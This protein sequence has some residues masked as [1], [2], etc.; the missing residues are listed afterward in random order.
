MRTPIL[1]ALRGH[2]LSFCDRFLVVASCFF[3]KTGQNGPQKFAA[4]HSIKGYVS[5]LLWVAFC[6]FGFDEAKGQF[7]VP[8]SGGIPYNAQTGI[9]YDPG[10]V[11]DYGNNVDGYAY[12]E[13][14]PGPCQRIVL[15]GNTSGENCCD[16]IRIYE[17][18]GTGGT[19]LATYGV[20]AGNVSFTGPPGANISV[21]FSS[22]V[23]VTGQGFALAWSLETLS[24]SASMT[25]SNTDICAGSIITLTSGYSISTGLATPTYLWSTGETTADIQP[26]PTNTTTYTVTVSSGACAANA[27]TNINV[28]ANPVASVSGIAT[29]CVGESTT[30]N[31]SGGGTYAWSTGATTNSINVSPVSTTTYTV[32]VTNNG[33]TA[34]ASQV[35]SVNNL[36]GSLAFQYQ[37]TSGTAPND[38]T[39]CPNVPVTISASG[40]AGYSWGNGETG[41]SISATLLQTGTFSLTVSSQSGCTGSGVATVT[42]NALASPTLAV[43][44]SDGVPNDGVICPGS[45]AQ[46]TATGGNTFSWSTGETT[47]S[48]SASLPS[49]YSVS[50]TDANGCSGSTSTTLL[51]NAAATAAIAVSDNS[52]VPNDGVVCPGGSAQF[53]ASGG[54]AYLWST[55]ETTATISTN[56]PGS[57]N[58]SVTNG[59]GCAATA[60]STLSTGTEPSLAVSS[61]G[62]YC[63]GQTILF[64]ATGGATYAWTGPGA[65]T[66]NLAAPIR[67]NATV[68]MTGTYFVTATSAE[69][70]T[71]SSNTSVVV[72]A[73]IATATNT[74]PYCPTESIELEAQ[75]G[76]AFQW[77]GPSGF[78]SIL[79]APVLPNANQG[80]AGTYSVTVS[81]ASGCS[82]TAQTTVVLLLAPQI[83]VGVSENSAQAPN[84]GIICAGSSAVLTGNDP[85]NTYA[86]STGES[87][88][89]VTITPA[90]TA[91]YLVTATNA[92]GCTATASQAIVVNPLPAPPVLTGDSIC[93]GSQA[94][95][96]GT[97]TGN[98]HW[99]ADA[100]GLNLLSIGSLLGTPPLQN[101]TTYW[102][103]VVSNG[104]T[105]P[106]DS[107]D[108][109]VPVLAPAPVGVP[110]A[111]CAGEIPTLEAVGTGGTLEWFVDPSATQAVASGPTFSPGALFVS[112]T[113]WVGERVDGCLGGRT[114][115]TATIFATPLPPLPTGGSACTDEVATLGATATDGLVHWFDAANAPTEIAT[116]STFVTTPLTDTTV[117]WAGVISPEGCAGPRV[118]VTAIW[119]PPPPPATISGNLVYC[120][121]DTLQLNGPDL[122]GTFYVWEG[123]NGLGGTAPS[124]FYGNLGDAQSG[125]Y[126]LTLY[127]A[128]G[129]P[130]T[131]DTVTV[132]INPLPEINGIIEQG[133]ASH[134][135]NDTLRL[136]VDAPEGVAYAWTLADGTTF[137]GPSVFID[138]LVEADHQGFYTLV[139]TD[140]A[141]GCVSSVYSALVNIN[142]VPHTADASNNGPL[143]PGETAILQATTYVGATYVWTRP[144]GGPL[145]GRQ[146]SI[147]DVSGNNAGTYTVQVTTADGC[148]LDV[149]GQTILTVHPSPAL[150]VSAPDST[151]EGLDVTLSAEGV[152]GFAWSPVTALDNTSVANPVAS[153][154]VPGDY[155][156]TVTL[157]DANNCTA[158]ASVSFSV[159]EDTEIVVETAFTPNGDGKNDLFVIRNVEHAQPNTLVVFSRGGA[160]VFETQNYQHDW[161]GLS[162]E[163][164]LPPGTYWYVFTVGGRVFKGAVTILHEN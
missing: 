149:Q 58:V 153:G 16:F 136:S 109:T 141:T 31:A 131:P 43:T 78:A 148:L 124:I 128:A 45:S 33:C 53:T 123:P 145:S 99:Y 94:S 119:L 159:F 129:C 75:G 10:F 14:N 127:S 114:P 110:D 85:A 15:Q 151:L 72:E 118:P 126:Q 117:W 35:V 20:N 134:C 49:T 27:S 87:T 69:G 120:A 9:L 7:I 143:C 105:G 115:V 71:A 26:A 161:G 116:G 2:F 51:L 30:L 90:G 6:C 103:A 40:W 1:G 60:T 66:S 8:V 112:N 137:D 155:T 144:G 97:G 152:G 21:R 32:T 65:F 158:V 81:N 77:S 63:A 163:K 22:D 23:S 89:N 34:S 133:G 135:E 70:C 57:Y 3:E 56:M 55:G 140:T 130:S 28:T 95:L 92:S 88:L 138:S 47:P 25:A 147:S 37:E 64:T 80:M 67:D 86:W 68:G 121:G 98:I 17:G 157:T 93:P 54:T 91:V 62:P 18:N 38:G 29:L 146:I 102:A 5:S 42:V 142:P 50:V 106:L 139:I 39:V 84:D 4:E 61:G 74:G 76:T 13:L 11:L 113:W 107:V 104:C 108:A 48:I 154:L 24:I 83:G 52:G 164:L 132:S 19:L 36:G 160:A 111:V 96:T 156:Y 41:S 46:F 59:S 44:E 101:T 100:A 73:V 150:S 122:P 125:D 82:A 162:N 79:E 12:L